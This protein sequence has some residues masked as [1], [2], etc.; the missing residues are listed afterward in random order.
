MKGSGAS[1]KSVDRNGKTHRIQEVNMA[2]PLK[3]E[4]TNA[5]TVTLE[6]VCHIAF[7][8]INR[9]E[10]LNALNEAVVAQLAS[11]FDEAEENPSVKAI[12]LRGAGKVFVAG[13]DI[14]FFIDKIKTGAVADIEAFAS[15]CH[16]VFLKIENSQKQTIALLDGL[17]L[18]GGSE[19]ALACNAI[20]A[21]PAGS[22]GFP[23]TGIGIYPGLGGMLRL[24]KKVGGRLAKYY[25]L[26]GA[27]MSAGDA[28]VL[29]VVNQVVDQTGVEAAL[30]S[31]I[32]RG[33]VDKYAPRD[34]PDRFRQF[35]R[36]FYPD[37]LHRMLS[38]LPPVDVPEETAEK[39]LKAL[40]YK[41]PL[42][43]LAASDVI[44]GQVH[45][46]IEEG[47]ALELSRMQEMFLTADAL[48]GIS[49][50]G[51]KRPEFKGK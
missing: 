25:V 44:D 14:R 12:V 30:E 5:D 45:V 35:E 4:G 19:L 23:E 29:G 2:P 24:A 28:E 6:V 9:P 37:N 41:A 40:K 1:K 48:E 3:N 7:I 51:I 22:L 11:K 21:T 46:S 47:I 36:A 39:I 42:A 26:T 33:R 50:A 38:G 49:S 13:A 34:L 43:L 16:D 27:H 31:M 32:D 10:A 17:S 20:L 8:T 18:G 15:R